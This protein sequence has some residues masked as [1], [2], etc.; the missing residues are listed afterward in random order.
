MEERSISKWSSSQQCCMLLVRKG[1]KHVR[2]VE[3]NGHGRYLSESSLL[4]YLLS[5]MRWRPRASQLHYIRWSCFGQ[6]LPESVPLSLY[7]SLA[8][9]HFPTLGQCSQGCL[10][11]RHRQEQLEAPSFPP[12]TRK[13]L[14]ICTM[15][16]P[17]MRSSGAPLFSPAPFF[18]GTPLSITALFSI[19]AG[20]HPLFTSLPG[21][22]LTHS[23]PKYFPR[24]IH[25]YVF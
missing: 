17:F 20:S 24:Y 14:D 18:S 4:S 25:I 12:L 1:W 21:T 22:V 16:C 7:Q 13:L 9:K 3:R 8:S 15:W 5:T 10:P 19:Q 23:F 11:G 2:W 6:L